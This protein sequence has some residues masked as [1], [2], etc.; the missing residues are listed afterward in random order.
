MYKK[1]LNVLCFFFIL[2]G[3]VFA[4]NLSSDQK[5][6]QNFL[7]ENKYIFIPDTKFFFH[8]YKKKKCK[9]VSLHHFW[10]CD[11][12]VTVGEYRK[13]IDFF[14][15]EKKEDIVKFLTPLDG[16]YIQSQFYNDPAHYDDP[17]RFVSLKQIERYCEWLTTSNKLNI[18]F[19]IIDEMQWECIATEAVTYLDKKKRVRIKQKI[20]VD[21][22]IRRGEKEAGS[23]I[24]ELLNVS[25]NTD[26]NNNSDKVSSYKKYKPSQL[27]FYD[28]IGNCREITVSY[29]GGKRKYRIGKGA[30]Y[31]DPY[32]LIKIEDIHRVE[33]NKGYF[34]YGFRLV[35]NFPMS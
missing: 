7:F 27:G 4:K 15:K 21:E 24:T 10:A 26:F 5:K 34:N 2:T 9:I 32:S 19:S 13:C 12:K 23:K 22:I 8:G 33:E 3:F 18:V 30:Y 29:Y 16:D 17:I 14:K 35:A 20:S 31:G 25:V 11:H 6:A 1:T 28:I